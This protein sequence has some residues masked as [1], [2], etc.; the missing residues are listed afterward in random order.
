MLMKF[1]PAIPKHW[2]F[3]IAGFIWTVVGLMLCVRAVTWLSSTALS[4]NF[5]V[6]M[7][8]VGIA[9]VGYLVMFSKVVQKNIVRILA[10]P[11]R[12]CAFA[13]TPWKGYFMIACMITIGI[14]LRNSSLPKYYLVI[15]YT[16]MGVIL[17][18]GSFVFFRQFVTKEFQK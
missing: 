15:P 9:G 12:A 14:I 16:A 5:F 8:A 4:F 13:F 2:L 1:R 18:I 6:E 17:L 10:L 7:I 3:I 11:D